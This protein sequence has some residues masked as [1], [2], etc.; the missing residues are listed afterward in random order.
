M[1]G[2]MLR[3][4]ILGYCVHYKYTRILWLGISTI[5]FFL[6]WAYIRPH[7]NVSGLIQDPT[8]IIGSVFIFESG[9]WIRPNVIW[10]GFRI[11]PDVSRSGSWIYP[12]IRWSGSWSWLYSNRYDPHVHHGSV[13]LKCKQIWILN[14][15]KCKWVRIQRPSEDEW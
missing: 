5:L 1:Y 14:P 8:K 13:H 3:T 12:N 4:G 15:S 7:L 9:A 2:K 10:P 6:H 11:R